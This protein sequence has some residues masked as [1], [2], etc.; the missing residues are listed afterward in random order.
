MAVSGYSDPF[1]STPDGPSI[2]SCQWIQ[3]FKAFMVVSS[4]YKYSADNKKSLLLY[5]LVWEVQ[6]LVYYAISEA[7]IL[8]V[9][10]DEL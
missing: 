10:Y 4:Y 5:S 8:A 9:E 7:E 3:M 1:L 6:R 2:P